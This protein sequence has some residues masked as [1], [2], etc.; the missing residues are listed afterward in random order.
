MQTCQLY[1]NTKDPSQHLFAAAAALY[2][3]TGEMKY[4][5]DVDLL[6]DWSYGGYLYNWNNVFPQ[7]PP[8]LRTVLHR[9]RTKGCML[10]HDL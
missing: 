10:D 9:Y 3:L 4:R 5:T 6:F 1:V 2:R 8:P 7:V